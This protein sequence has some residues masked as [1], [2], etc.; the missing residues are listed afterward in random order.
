MSETR[1]V[2]LETSVDT[3]GATAG[4]NEIQRG[5]GTMAAAV[6]RA[7]EQADAAVDGIGTSATASARNVEAAER[8]ITNAIQR[9]IAAMRAGASGTASFYENI[10]QQRGVDT[11]GLQPLLNQLRELEQAQTRANTAVG[12]ASRP[13]HQVEISAAQTAAALRSVPAQFTDIV[14]QLQG[15]QSPMTILFQQGGQLRDM[16]GSAGGAARALGGYVIGLVTPFT[17]A[18]AAVAGL[19]YA[20]KKGRDEMTAF[21]MAIITSGNAAGATADQLSEVARR[22][23]EVS[24]NRAEAAAALNGLV[25]TGQVQAQNLQAFAQVAVD[26]Q[27]VMGRSIEQTTADF[28]K[29]GKAPLQGL[30]EINA[31]YHN[32]TAATYAQVKA[33]QEQGRYAEAASVAQQSYADGI[34]KQK[35]AVLDSLT[36]WERGW[37]RIKNGISGAVD[38][39][40]NLREATASEKIDKL[41]K[42]NDDTEARI[43]SLKKRGE[44]R[45]G[46]S[47]D[48]AKDPDVLAAQAAI[49]AN[50]REIQSI[51]GKQDAKKKAAT[52]DAKNV[53]GDAIRQQIT[54]AEDI[55]KTPEQRLKDL[56]AAAEQ[57]DR[58]NGL[59]DEEVAKHRAIIIR[60]NYDVVTASI[61]R[62]IAA[63]RLRNSLDDLKAEPA[64][65]QIN[66]DRSTGAI[67]YDEALRRTAQLDL[68]AL[69]RRKKALEKQIGVVNQLVDSDQKRSQLAELNGQIEE[70]NISRK[71]REQKLEQD[72]LL[73]DRESVKASA[74]AFAQY[75]DQIYNTRLE[76][77]NQVQQQKDYNEEIGLSSREVLD[78]TA[79]R[80]EERAARLDQNA[81]IAEG[82]DLTGELA[83]EYRRQAQELRNLSA[84]EREGFIKQRDPYVNLRQS[85]NRYVEESQNS[86][87]MIGDALTNAFRSAEDAFANFVTTGKLNFKDLATSIL[88]DFARIQA[89]A[90][91]GGLAQ[92]LL[93][94]MGT[95]T[96]SGWGSSLMQALGVSGA[97]AAGG[98]VNSGLSYL[99]GENGPEIFTPSGNGSITPNHL[100]GASGGAPVS[101]S[102]STV[103]N[104]NSSSTQTSGNTGTNSR[105]AIDAL[106][107]SF[108]QWLAGEVRQGGMIW[109]LQQGRA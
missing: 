67:N 19:A 87:A 24:G 36:D 6:A 28:E 77:R 45:D 7:S 17:V 16:F 80:R 33:L 76:M 73:A 50:V 30:A 21:N 93:G 71:N 64:A 108:K 35:Q 86:G 101:V 15:G 99:V 74:A 96:T 58:A 100:I 22:I 13:L 1:A 83:D 69:D 63:I 84:A 78:L 54:D 79:A 20:Y 55:L 38:A 66:I 109:K 37:L 94:S 12:G 14:T 65:G 42:A 105:A 70:V 89:K 61:E 106:H 72:S 18:A 26:A 104:G 57:N 107:A 97:R 102:F 25:Q 53:R 43:A 34:T 56:L 52:E 27:R 47:Y 31:K 62:Q 23:G 44:A 85:L 46:K 90:A 49:D 39:V 75:Y 95:S 32:V 4:F 92:S 82:L 10:A 3:T 68:D 91:I 11:G 2:T 5:A 8:N 60:Q 59:N 88:A 98:P 29:L 81:D 41:L 9:R 103:I 51:R 48:P 40:F